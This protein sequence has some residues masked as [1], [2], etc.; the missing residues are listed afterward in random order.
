MSSTTKTKSTSR[1]HTPARRTSHHRAAAAKPA[2]SRAVA[3]RSVA[4][5]AARPETSLAQRALGKV[6]TK[7]GLAVVAGMVLAGVGGLAAYKYRAAR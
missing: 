3:T 2:P 4:T 5:P 7:T 1:S 6:K